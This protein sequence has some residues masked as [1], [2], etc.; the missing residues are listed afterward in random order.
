MEPSEQKLCPQI[1]RQAVRLLW[2]WDEWCGVLSGMCLYQ[3]ERYWFEATDP[4]DETMKFVFPRR[5]GLYRLS[6][7]ELRVQE[8]I[9]QQFQRYV[10]MHTDYDENE[11]LHR[12]V[13]PS[14]EQEW[15]KY[16]MWLKQQ[17]GQPFDYSQNE[18]IGWFELD[19]S[20]LYP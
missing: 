8:E 15:E 11:Q 16:D 19:K 17:P 1:P 14:Q 5:M 18:M 13:R 7:E 10:G 3:G 12:P 4:L 9:H 2:Y 20:E 6:L